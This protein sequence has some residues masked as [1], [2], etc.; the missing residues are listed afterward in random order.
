MEVLERRGDARAPRLGI[1]LGERSSID[2]DPSGRRFVELEEELHE[3]R[4]ARAIFAHDRN[5]RAD[6]ERDRYVVE[7]ARVGTGIRERDVLEPDLVHE[8]RRRGA[9]P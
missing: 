9:A 4:L 6:G 1:D 7:Y 5:D 2:E 8:T 3:R